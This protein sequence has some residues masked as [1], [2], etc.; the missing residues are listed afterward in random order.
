MLFN[1]PEFLLAFFPATLLGFFLL[2]RLSTEAAAAWLGAASLVFYGWW[3]LEAVPLL[4]GSIGC[5]FAV[6]R[7]LVPTAPLS[8][9]ARRH[10]MYGAVATNLALLGFFKYANF[11]VDNM[12]AGLGASG[13]SA[14]EALSIVL[15][16]GISF[17]TFTQIA[18][19]VDGWKGKVA[20][21]NF[22][23]YLLFVT[24]FPH[25]I[26]GPVLHHSQMMPQFASA[27]TYRF[28]PR[29]VFAGLT[30]FSVGLAKKVIVADSLADFVN[31]AFDQAALGETVSF[32]DGWAAAVGY[33]LQLYFD[34][35]GYSD[36]AIGISLCFGVQLPINFNSPYRATSII[37]F[38]RR[39]N[40]SLSTFL[41]DYLYIPL[42]GNKL[43]PVRRHINLFITM[44]FGGLWHG[45]SWNFVL[46]GALHGIFLAVNH[47]WRH[48]TGAARFGIA[49]RC[50]AWF[51][52]FICVCIAWVLFRAADLTTAASI[53]RGMMGLNGVVL[54]EQVAN[55]LP[56]LKS[57]I[58]TVGKMPTLGAGSVMGVFEQLVITV[59]GLAIAL[60]G[61]QAIE[62]SSNARLGLICLGAGFAM[63]SI[64][65]ALPKEF[66]YFQF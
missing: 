50:A 56:F 11:F 51:I 10:L 33:A 53:Y 22:S 45:A 64:F 36:M 62:L 57:M 4:L 15:P 7:W 44:V 46:W 29:T 12:N 26:A 23:H 5:N 16:I 54:P 19:L 6:S 28:N 32:I 35:S 63:H 3:S 49:G 52:T 61:K 8:E 21:R 41:R 59:F 2:A 55:L 39:W 17:Y 48:F 31:P 38:W 43:G 14:V 58:Y 40:I 37:D 27:Q 13:G 20:E 34:F 47:A 66:L 60:L 30:I 65:F 25:L 24:Y 9:Q 18:F 42:G 1:S